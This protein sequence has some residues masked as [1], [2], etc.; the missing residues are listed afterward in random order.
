LAE[1]KRKDE[2]RVQVKRD[3]EEDRNG[4]K[5]YREELSRELPYLP[6]YLGRSMQSN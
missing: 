5:M 4:E 1:E 2:M 6:A 3:D